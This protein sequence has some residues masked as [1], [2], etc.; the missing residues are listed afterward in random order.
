[1]TSVNVNQFKTISAFERYCYKEC[2]IGK[3]PIEGL[4]C[5]LRCKIREELRKIHPEWFGGKRKHEMATSEV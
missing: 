2:P 5:A 1:M 3:D 4:G